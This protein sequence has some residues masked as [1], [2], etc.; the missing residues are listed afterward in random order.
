MTYMDEIAQ[1]ALEGLHRSYVR[2]AVRNLVISRASLKELNKIK[3]IE[4]RK[5][6]WVPKFNAK[7]AE[8]IDH[9]SI[10]VVF[11]SMALEAYINYYGIIKL[12][13][14]FWKA[15]LKNIRTIDKWVII[16]QLATGKAYPKDNISYSS[17]QKLFSD[18]N[19]LA[20]YKPRSYLVINYGFDGDPEEEDIADLLGRKSE[21]AI[22]TIELMAADMLNIDP[23]SDAINH[24]APWL[25]RKKT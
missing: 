16:P 2:I 14:S 10:V 19:W 9:T 4:K 21:R 5:R 18:R 23:E 13:R 25:R 1:L 7:R 20:H 22:K 17:L 8:Y 12:G 15:H 11:S 24:L 6:G 3:A